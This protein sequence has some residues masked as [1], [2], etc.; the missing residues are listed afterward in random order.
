MKG[1]I[2]S[3]IATCGPIGYLKWAPGSFGS[4]LAIPLIWLVGKNLDFFVLT[5]IALF[6]VAV[7]SSN[8]VACDLKEHDPAPVVI[9]E[10]CGMFLSLFLIFPTWRTFLTGF[11]CFRFFDIVKPRPLHWLERFPNGF[12]IVLDDIGAGI[13]TNIILHFLVHYAHL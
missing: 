11:I 8:K 1:R 12:G 4:L 9:D 2:A 6:S 13:Y 10:V 3:W 7:W 5:F